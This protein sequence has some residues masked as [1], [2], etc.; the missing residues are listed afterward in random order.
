MMTVL[1]EASAGFFVAAVVT[2]LCLAASS[3]K[4]EA[5]TTAAY[6]RR[7]SSRVYGGQCCN[8]RKRLNVYFLMLRWGLFYKD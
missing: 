1:A 3:L 4:S 2:L 6:D 7:S 8:L 5:R